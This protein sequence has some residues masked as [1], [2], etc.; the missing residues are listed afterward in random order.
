MERK[1]KIYIDTSVIGGCFDEEFAEWSN[2]LFEEFI[3][4]K[5]ITVISNIVA[6]ELESAPIYIH[7][8]LN[9]IPDANILQLINNEES[10]LL[11]KKYIEFKAIS[12]KY[13]ND[14]LHIAIASI[15]NIDILVSWNFKHI[16]NY[17]RIIVYNAV[18]NLFGYKNIEIRTPKEVV[19]NEEDF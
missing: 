19:F 14:A 13:Y 17:N 5:R 11:A 2:M 10:E 3:Q 7:E 4:G 16:V 15:N 8:K 9:E 6:N 12:E 18:N 1:L